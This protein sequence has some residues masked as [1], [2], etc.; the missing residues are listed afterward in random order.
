MRTIYNLLIVNRDS[1]CISPT[2]SIF[3]PLLFLV[4]TNDLHCA[5]KYCKVHHFADDT[6]L[7]NFQAS[8]KKINIQINHD[9]K[10][11]PNWLNDNKIALNLSKIELVMFSPPKKQLENELKIKLNGKKLYQTDSVLYLGI[12][13][14]GNAK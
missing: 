14:P 8:I 6:N 9:L 3:G 2:G 7:I 11:L 4:Y 1:F 10:N 13:L 5:I 12:P